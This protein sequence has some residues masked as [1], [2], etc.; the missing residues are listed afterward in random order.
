MLQYNQCS[1]DESMY[2]KNFIRRQKV[3]CVISDVVIRDETNDG[4][5]LLAFIFFQKKE[6]EKTRW[7]R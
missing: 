2:S 4:A 7:G 6:T 1:M 5:L 3:L